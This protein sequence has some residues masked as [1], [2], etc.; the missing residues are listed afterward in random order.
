MMTVVN[1]VRPVLHSRAI[2]VPNMADLF[3]S[4]RS[5]QSLARLSLSS[6]GTTFP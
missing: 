3:H 1:K 6:R 2:L 4:L 5:S